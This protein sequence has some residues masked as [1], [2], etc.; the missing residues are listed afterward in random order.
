[1]TSSRVVLC[2]V[3][4]SLAGCRSL[5]GEPASS[6]GRASRPVRSAA[7]EAAAA[8]RADSGGRAADGT[9]TS[10]AGG[11]SG[12]SADSTAS[13]G[14]E[15]RASAPV[16]APTAAAPAREFGVT[17]TEITIWND[18]SFRKWFAASY[19]AE[20]DVEPKLTQ[21]EREQ[22]QKVLDLIAL[23]DFTQATALLEKLLTPASSATIDYTLAMI[24]FQRDDLANAAPLYRSAVEK[25]PK[26]RRAWRNLGLIRVRGGDFVGT[27]EALTKV[28]ELGGADSVTYGLLGFAYSNTDNHMSAESAYRMANLLDPKTLDWKMGLARSFF[29]QKRFADAAALCGTLAA[30]Q[31]D[32]ADLWLLQANAYVGMNQPMKAAENYEIVERLGKSTPESLATLGDIY[33]NQELYELAATAYLK[34]MD[35]STDG[36]VE[37]PLR[38]AKVL[39]ARGALVE[40]RRLVERIDTVYGTKLAPEEKKDLLKLKARL[41]VAEGAGE[42]EAR[43]LEEIVALDP[44]D[45]EALILLG[46]HRSKAGDVEKAVFYYE[47]AAG[48][49][50]F[51]ADAK[52][53]HAQLLVGQGKYAEALPLLRRAQTVK[54]RENIQQY[55]EQVERVAAGR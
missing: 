37:R 55:L 54:P 43:V 26:F 38:A 50:A 39:T 36:K 34:S 28:I 32:R 20:S 16:L 48:L 47:R 19:A 14:A 44:L 4:S 17:E 25:F 18:P 10:D 1:M 2:L 6:S 5:D 49:E 7:R 27:I 23:E 52:V 33:V 21:P 13:T 12:Q 42:E 46:Q 53:R 15:T 22:M 9:S 11:S 45:G 40:T 8:A 30:D 24:Y 35:K 29:K 41:A 51:E 3:L 31:P